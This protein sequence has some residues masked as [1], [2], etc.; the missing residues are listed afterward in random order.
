M[1][2]D[3]EAYRTLRTTVVELARAHP[4][5][6]DRIAP[7]TPAWQARDLLAHLGGVCDDVVNG[8][9]EGVGTNPWTAA[10]VDKRAAW[11]VEEILVD[12]EQHGEA[13]DALIDGT[14][15][16][17]FGQLLYDAWTHEQDLRGFLGTPGGRDTAAA[18]RAYAWG[19]DAFAL[20]DEAEQRPGLTLATEHG[21]R[22]VG[23]GDPSSTVSA[24]RFELL[25]AMTGRRSLAQMRAFQWEG[26]PDPQRLVLAADL[27]TP[28]VADLHE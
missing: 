13:L 12:W 19:T 18:E 23:V 14:P 15:P 25:R 22:T 2:T 28:P 1:T 8:K 16:G 10:Q 11:S 20:R 5:D 3:A 21:T 17:T 7:A 4:A 9:L 24:S 6:L 27:F 26:D